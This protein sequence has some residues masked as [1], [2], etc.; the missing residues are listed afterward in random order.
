MTQK[1]NLKLMQ[2]VVKVKAYI[3]GLELIDGVDGLT[4][5]RLVTSAFERKYNNHR[6]FI[7]AGLTKELEAYEDSLAIAN[8][9][10]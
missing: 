9:E 5:A 3:E 1:E 10:K 7:T 6:M 4:A 8:T 2:T